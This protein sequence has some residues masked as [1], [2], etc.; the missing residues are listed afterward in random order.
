MALFEVVVELVDVLGA[1]KFCV[2][3]GN[4]ARIDVVLE[5]GDLKVICGNV[6]VEIYSERIASRDKER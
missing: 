6:G 4:E 2:G 5:T 3:T 1:L